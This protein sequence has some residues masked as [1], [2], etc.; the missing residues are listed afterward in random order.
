[1][2]G[3]LKFLLWL[4]LGV[5]NL[6]NAALPVRMAD[7]EPLPTLAPMLEKVRPG[8][9]NIATYTTVRVRNPLLE[10][11]FFRR[12]FNVPDSQRYRRTTSAGSGVVVDAG[13]GYILTNNHVV[14][15][16]DDIEITLS[17]GRTIS[18][19][20]VGSD[21]QVDLA[22][23]KVD[24]RDLTEVAFGDSEALRVG[25][26]VVA[27]GNPFGLNQTVTSGIISAL[28]R[29]GLG[30][31]GYEDFIQTDA[32]INPGNSGG[33]LVDLAGN[34]VGIN[35]A[36][37]APSGGNVGIGFAI[38][39]NMARSIMQQLIEHGEVRRGYLGIEV[40]NLTPDLA[41]AFGVGRKEGVVISDVVPDSPAERAGLRS[42]DVITRMNAREIVRIGDFHSQAAVTFVGEEIAVKVMR[43]GRARDF[44]I[45]VGDGLENVRGGRIDNRLAGTELQNFRDSREGSIGDGVLVT[46]VDRDSGAWRDGLRPGDLIV[47]ANRRGVRNIVDLREN[48]RLATRGVL[49][50]VYRNGRFGNVQLRGG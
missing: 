29:S 36:I 37:F 25:D 43:E 46:D 20:L 22:V 45:E 24:G 30:I 33:A 28:G 9:V 34:L 12:F 11:P 13:E 1:M 2:T 15:R 31:E 7:G 38:P 6:A 32:S 21:P 14:E 50:R 35:T 17:D 44:E 26:F 19:Q 4:G 42:G 10:D 16:A 18:A 41:E 39:A 5:T 47:G 23:L 48:V 40:Q 3:V 49:L 8:V 27:I